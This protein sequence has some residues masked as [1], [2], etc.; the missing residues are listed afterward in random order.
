MYRNYKN[1]STI[2]DNKLTW[3]ANTNAGFAKAQ[4][5]LYFLRKLG[6]FYADYADPVLQDLH[7]EYIDVL[8][9]VLGGSIVFTKQ[10]QTG[11]GC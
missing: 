3:N 1:L 5:H 2:I 8:Y 6:S 10:E 9:S 7:S 4:Q 11:Q